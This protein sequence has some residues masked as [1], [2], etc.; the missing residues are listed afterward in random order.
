M[1]GSLVGRVL[2]KAWRPGGLEGVR[3]DL[4]VG[5]A[6]GLVVHLEAERLA[7]VEDA[8]TAD[9]QEGLSA[10]MEKRPPRV[11]GH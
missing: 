11:K 6:G 9:F 4:Q 1:P 2:L 5:R 8:S 7:Q 10:F 3:R